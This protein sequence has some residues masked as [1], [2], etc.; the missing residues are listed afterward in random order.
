MIELHIEVNGLITAD[1]RKSRQATRMKRLFG[2]YSVATVWTFAGVH[3]VETFGA[4]VITAIR[5]ACSPETVEWSSERCAEFVAFKFTTQCLAG[6]FPG[7][8]R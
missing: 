7:R 8:R 5:E 1:F 2:G 3:E 6:A 4:K